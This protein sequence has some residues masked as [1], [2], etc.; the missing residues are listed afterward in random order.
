MGTDYY[1]ARPD[2]RT[3]F[4]MGKAYGLRELI[5]LGISERVDFRVLYL[6]LVEWFDGEHQ[7]HV[8]RLMAAIQAFADG[9][10]IYFV[11]EH[12]PWLD[13]DTPWREAGSRWRVE[14][15]P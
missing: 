3:L 7:E 4:H 14:G 12:H 6:G 9:Q 8:T 15:S 1:F 2:N 13:E 11:T 5:G 10:P